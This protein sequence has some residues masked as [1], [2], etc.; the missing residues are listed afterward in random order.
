MVLWMSALVSMEI[1]VSITCRR[2]ASLMSDS[3]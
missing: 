3:M 2:I 1:I